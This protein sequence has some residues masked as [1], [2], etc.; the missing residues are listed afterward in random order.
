MCLK[1]TAFMVY[2]TVIA[3]LFTAS[4]HNNPQNLE[5]MDMCFTHGIIP[6]QACKPD[7]LQ[8]FRFPSAMNDMNDRSA[9]IQAS[10]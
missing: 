8:A 2:C 4:T 1:P 7:Q 5:Q 3:I 6:V 10:P 9:M